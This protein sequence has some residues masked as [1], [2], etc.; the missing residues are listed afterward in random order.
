MYIYL[1]YVYIYG[2][3]QRKQITNFK[4]WKT[5]EQ[6]QRKHLDSNISHE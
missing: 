3:P 4:N 6:Q 5:F 1:H 2:L